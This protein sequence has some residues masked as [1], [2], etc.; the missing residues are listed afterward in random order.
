MICERCI[1]Q[2]WRVAH[3]NEGG[4]MVVSCFDGWLFDGN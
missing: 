1:S 4:G 3:N 2:R